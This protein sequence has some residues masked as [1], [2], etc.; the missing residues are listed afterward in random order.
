MACK[1]RTLKKK[2]YEEEIIQIIKERYSRDI[3]ARELESRDTVVS[4]KLQELQRESDENN[5]W[6]DDLLAENKAL[7]E[8]MGHANELLNK[9]NEICQQ[10][11]EMTSRLKAQSAALNK[12]KSLLEAQV[13]ALNKD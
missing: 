10:Y 11:K 6:Y 1:G 4:Q 12:D 7:R 3:R 2:G 8:K 13:A 5:I 9:H